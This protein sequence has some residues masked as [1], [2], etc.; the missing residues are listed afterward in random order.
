MAQTQYLKRYKPDRVDPNAMSRS[1][2]LAKLALD[3]NFHT[4]WYAISKAIRAGLPY[5]SHP[6]F[7]RVV[8]DWNEVLAWLAANKTRRVPVV[9]EHRIAPRSKS[10]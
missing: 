5:H 1:E 2:L 10:A 4:S 8:F 6:I 9:T 3:I 7:D